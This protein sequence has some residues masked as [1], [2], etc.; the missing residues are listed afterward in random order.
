MTLALGDKELNQRKVSD[1]ADMLYKSALSKES[2]A[3]ANR[4]NTP[5]QEQPAPLPHPEAGQLTLDQWKSLPDEERAYAAY[6]HG[7]KLQGGDA[8]KPERLTREY[9]EKMEPTEQVK[10]LEYMKDR[11]DLQDLY[12]KMHP[13]N[14]PMDAFMTGVAKGQVAVMAP[15]FSEGVK[16]DLMKDSQFNYP[17]KSEVDAYKDNYKLT[18]TDAKKTLQK[19]KHLKEM[20][21]RIRQAFVGKKVERSAE[22]WKVDGKLIVRNPYYGK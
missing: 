6:V 11:P 22:G 21:S 9:F 8:A 18:Y 1:L 5:E 14:N 12:Q 15:D 2:I 10:T 16:Q 7:A 19:E 4:M 17:P 3:R 13:A 20:D